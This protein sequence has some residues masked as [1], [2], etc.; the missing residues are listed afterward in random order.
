[1]T[2]ANA[3][4]EFPMSYPNSATPVTIRLTKLF[5]D[6]QRLIDAGGLAA[7]AA[8]PPPL[9][10]GSVASQFRVVT[11]PL[12]IAHVNDWPIDQQELLLAAMIGALE[13]LATIS[14]DWE[15]AASTST[16]IVSFDDGT[17]GVTFRSPP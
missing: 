10:L 2:T 16:D 12:G 17:W 3:T 11:G 8:D 1:V 9:P 15:E 13:T 7:L 14:F 5:S 6:P 4:K